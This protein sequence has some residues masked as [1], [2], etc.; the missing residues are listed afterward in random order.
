MK[1]PRVATREEWLKART[2]LLRKE[3]DLTKKRDEV[4]SAVEK[5]ESRIHAINELFC[6]PTFFDRTAPGEVK[7]L[8]NEQKTLSTR[9]EELM[10]EWEK[11][12]EQIGEL[13][14]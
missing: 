12:E 9:V 14:A 4:T 2:D 8:E 11:L 3:K 1:L 13:G 10:G 7:K 6:D 5:A